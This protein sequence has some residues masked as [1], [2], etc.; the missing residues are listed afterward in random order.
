M[1]SGRELTLF[2][3]KLLKRLEPSD[4]GFLDR[5]RQMSFLSKTVFHLLFFIKVIQSE[6]SLFCI[7]LHA[8]NFKHD[9]MSEIL[10]THFPN[11]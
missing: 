7:S 3:G 2:W 5:C 11:P 6:V 4:Q 9:Q 10:N 1:F 8:V